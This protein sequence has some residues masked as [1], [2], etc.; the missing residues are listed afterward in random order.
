MTLAANLERE[1]I[2]RRKSDHFKANKRR[3][4]CHRLLS[5]NYAPDLLATT[6]KLVF[7]T[8]QF[9]E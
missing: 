1:S 2:E 8:S 4:T 6:R 7:S 5:S 9:Y 3:T